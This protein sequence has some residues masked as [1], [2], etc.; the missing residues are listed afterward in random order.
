MGR[1]RSQNLGLVLISTSPSQMHVPGCLLIE[2]FKFSIFLV[3]YGLRS[4]CQQL[5]SN[6]NAA[7]KISHMDPKAMQMDWADPSKIYCIYCLGATCAHFEQTWNIILCW[8][9]SLATMFSKFVSL[10][11]IWIQTGSLKWFKTQL[12]D[13]FIDSSWLL[14]GFLI[15]FSKLLQ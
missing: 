9:G 8:V 12:V 5:A 11:Q 13:V 14:G 10:L 15:T 7:Q 2:F 4:N 6:P 3:R 1:D